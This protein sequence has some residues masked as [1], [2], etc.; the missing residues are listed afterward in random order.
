M[1]STVLPTLLMLLMASSWYASP[2][3]LRYQM[4][5]IL[6]KIASSAAVRMP[7]VD[8]MLLTVP[9]T[10]LM[11]PTASS[12]YASPIELQYQMNGI[13]KIAS[14]AVPLPPEAILRPPPRP[15]LRLLP[16]PRLPRA[17]ATP[18]I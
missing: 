11:S 4:N 6:K 2:V 17:P 3:E 5:G 1:L 18:S 16:Q 9:P 10:L 8:P 7:T 12:W 14:S 15:P 13:L